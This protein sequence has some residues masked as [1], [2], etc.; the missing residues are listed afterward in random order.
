M[1]T[2]TLKSHLIPRV[3]RTNNKIATLNTAHLCHKCA[4]CGY[5][6]HPQSDYYAVFPASITKE[7]LEVPEHVHVHCIESHLLAL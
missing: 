6:I 4:E 5:P 1:E 2:T 7:S 3:I